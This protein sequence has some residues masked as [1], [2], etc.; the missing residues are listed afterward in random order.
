MLEKTTRLVKEILD[1]N[2]S[3]FLLDL[4]V[5][6]DHKIKIIIDGDQGVSLDDC[7]TVSKYV[8]Q[9]L[10]SEKANFSI[11]VSS[12]GAAQPIKNKRQFKKNIGRY[13]EIVLTNGE[14][15]AGKLKN[16][17]DEKLTLEWKVREPKP[18]GKGKR[19]V[20]KKAEKTYSDIEK[21]KVIIKF[22]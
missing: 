17:D 5:S 14:K 13:L 9:H 6:E 22:N 21:A 15:I 10:D 2:K 8:E 7:I 19:T 4:S 20:V 3:L 18:I 1:K 16:A 11:E 12:P